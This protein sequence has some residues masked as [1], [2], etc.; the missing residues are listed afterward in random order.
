MTLQ[1]RAATDDDLDALA[2]MGAALAKLHQGWDAQRFSSKSTDDVEDGYRWWFSKEI[3]RKGVCFRVAVDDDSD[4]D[5]DDLA[6]YIYGCKEGRDWNRL[7]DPHVE[8]VDVYVRHD[9]RH[10]G[11]GKALIESFCAWAEKKK[12]GPVVLSTAAKNAEA[13]ALFASLGFRPTMIE[14]TR[15]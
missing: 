12:A 15:G 13:Q 10:H 6:G 2:A 4:D 14:M 5:S 7:L 3:Q 8:I 1:V 11:V 9:R